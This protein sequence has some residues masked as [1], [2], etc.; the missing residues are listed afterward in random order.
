MSRH[1]NCHRSLEQRIETRNQTI[2]RI[3]SEINLQ[4]GM[5]QWA[6][7]ICSDVTNAKIYPLNLRFFLHYP[8][9]FEKYAVIK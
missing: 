9:L 3:N 5:V 7:I 6:R 8:S 1:K 4:A 2:D